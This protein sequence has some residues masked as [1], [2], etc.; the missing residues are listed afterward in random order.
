MSMSNPLNLKDVSYELERNDNHPSLVVAAKEESSPSSSPSQ[1]RSQLAIAGP[2]L[3]SSFVVAALMY[4]LGRVAK[5]SLFF[6]HI[7]LT[8]CQYIDVLNIYNY[9]I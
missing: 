7:L 1:W 6:H 5:N 4:P 3:A 8:S 9:Y 2:V